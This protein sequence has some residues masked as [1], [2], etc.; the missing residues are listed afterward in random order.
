MSLFFKKKLLTVPT[1]W[2]WLVLIPIPFLLFYI[3]LLNTY[4]FLA[5]EEPTSSDVLVVEGWIPEKGLK[6]AIEFYYKNDYK[7]MII[8]GVPIT[9]W[10]YSSPYSNMADASAKSMKMMLF[11]DSIY[12]V[13]IP[14]NVVRDRTY[15]TAVAL[16]M[17]MENGN[18]PNKNFD[19]YTVGAH[20]RRSYLMFSKAFPDRKIGLI[21]DIDDSYD[22]P[23]WFKTSYGFRIVSSEFIS[24]IYSRIFFYPIEN[25]IRDLIIEGR[26]IDTIQKTRF[27][28]DNEFADTTTSP[29]KT[30][31]I[32]L[33][34]GLHYFP[35]NKMWK[36]KA[37][38]KFDTLS[39]VFKMP[40]S[41]TRLPEY[42]KYGILTFT[43]HDT[44]FQLTAYQ[45]IDLL[46]K[47]PETKYL[48]LPFK[49]K[50][51]N[52]STYGAGRYIDIEIPEND[53]VI[54][55]FNLAYNPYCAYS[56]RWSC[57]IPPPENYLNTH[58]TAGEKKYH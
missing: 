27:A 10:S 9:Q 14:S 48:F 6:N 39:P 44:I 4:D 29:L 52:I 26:H 22:P 12:T 32:Q 5:I 50:S 13:S 43:L 28:K 58:I 11:R 1:L 42:K 30:T 56:D 25:E 24:Y 17:S 7:W 21:T 41:T 40:T 47:N 35:I 16:K 34:R 2:G 45:N 49:D 54:I 15:S 8:T 57:P 18:V 38:F 46:K 19:I 37:G 20:A 23:V 51:N 36:V 3:L 31:E 53:T 55:D 33:F